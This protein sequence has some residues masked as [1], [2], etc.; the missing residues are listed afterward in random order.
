[1][2]SGGRAQDGAAARSGLVG[3][4]VVVV[5]G[6]TGDGPSASA[7]CPY[8]NHV[9]DRDSAEALLAATPGLAGEQ[10]DLGD[11][12]ALGRELFGALV[13]DER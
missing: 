3:V 10:L 9:S 11:A 4:G 1:M 8:L 12:V 5:V 13:E 7:C 2:R 6:R